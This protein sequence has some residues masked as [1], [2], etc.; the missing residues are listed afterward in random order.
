VTE[1]SQKIV[2]GNLRADNLVNGRYESNDQSISGDIAGTIQI[3]DLNIKAGK[4]NITNKASSTQKVVKNTSD[5]VT[6]F[7]GEITAKDGTVSVTDLNLEGTFSTGLDNKDQ[8]SLTVYV[9]GEPYSDAVY[10]STNTK[11]SF[12]NLGDVSSN[13]PMKVKITAQPNII[14]LTGSITFGVSAE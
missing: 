3:A 8:I 6:I 12:A 5:V 1:N 11:V 13:N 14:D 10:K 9:D 4:F 2:F 7:D